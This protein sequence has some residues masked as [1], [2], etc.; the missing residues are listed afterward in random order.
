MEITTNNNKHIINS[1]NKAIIFSY[2][3]F[4]STIAVWVILYI[5]SSQANTN[6]PK[7]RFLHEQFLIS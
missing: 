7:Q 3:T 5:S 1:V 2:A 6:S 4:L